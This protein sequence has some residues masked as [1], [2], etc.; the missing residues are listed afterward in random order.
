MS[1]KIEIIRRENGIFRHV[2]VTGELLLNA[3]IELLPDDTIRVNANNYSEVMQPNEIYVKDEINDSLSVNYET[4]S[5]LSA[6]LKRLG[7]TDWDIS[8]NSGEN[9]APGSLIDRELVATTYECKIAFAGASIGDTITCT[10][11]IDV[12]GTPTNISTIWRNQTTAANLV[13]VPSASN[14]SLLG[15]Q[16]LTNA[17]LRAAALIVSGNVNANTGLEQPL[18]NAELR[19]A[20]IAISATNLPLPLGASTEATL[21]AIKQKTDNID[22]ALSTRTKPADV[23]KTDGSAVVQPISATELPL[24]TGAAK[25]STLNDIKS[26]VQTIDDTVAQIGADAPAKVQAMGIVNP[27][28]KIVPA[29]STENGAMA[30]GNAMKKFR[31]G[32]AD[33]A[34]GALPD[35]S[36]WDIEW[37]SK[38]S[39]F[40]G[41][42]GDA[43]GASYMKISL[44]PITAGS[45]FSMITKRTFK[46]PMRFINMLSISQRI[47]GQEF[48]IS[49]VGVDSNG[50]IVTLTPKADLAISGIVGITSNIATINFASPHGLKTSDR[51][52]LVG[53]T[54]RRLNVGPVQ[55]TVVNATQITVPC[56]LANGTY[57]AGGVVRWADP[58]A[59]AK[60]GAGLLHENATA[61]NA[62][63]LTRR[64]GFN[65][66][67]LNSTIANTSNATNLGY[68]DPFQ[69]TSMNQIIA[70]Q[71]EFTIIPRSPDT[72]T[73]PSTPLKWHQGIPDE[74]IEY[75]IRI[76][77]KNLDNLTRPIARIITINKTG[78]TTATVVTDTPHGLTTT[79]FVQI[80]GVRDQNNFPTLAVQ[81]QVASVIDANTFTIIIGSA[82]SASS[83]GGTVVINQ[84]SVLFPGGSNVAVQSISR[85]NNVL[86]LIGNGTWTGFLPGETI[87][88]YGCDAT[89][90]G[91]YDGA[92]KVLRLATTTLEL[93]SVGVDFGSINCGGA[94]VRRTDL[95]INGIS[96]I[97]HTR[98][99]AELSNSQGSLDNSKAMPA[100]VVNTPS[101]VQSGTWNVGVTSL[102]ALPAGPNLIGSVSFPIPILVADIASAALTTTATTAA[103]TP[104]A[105][106]SYEINI[107]VTAVTGTNPTLDI[108]IE[109]SDDNGTNWYKV[110]DFPRITAT[111]MYR[112]PKL[113]LT[114]NRIRY[115]QT[116]GGTTPSFTRSLNRLQITDTIASIRQLIDR[117]VVLTTLNSVTPSINVQNCGNIQLAINVGTITTTAPQIQLQGSD[118]NG[119]TWYSIGTPLTAVASQT[120]SL[121]VNDN[122]AQ[123]VRAIVS[124][125]GVGVTAG[126]TLIK[127]Y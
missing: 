117:T 57:A 15:S 36:I 12:T 46:Y 4:A 41:R 123:L 88:L 31:D 1:K 19:A 83:T 21:L 116:V 3:Y 63:F 64:N 51:I 80:Y 121:K 126:Y 84:G 124:T 62:T 113:P 61:T 7:Y 87:H 110:Y 47:L 107:P 11:I 17:Q 120:V 115:V 48:E 104:G 79:D 16:A 40:A 103:F 73:A 30:I 85:T 22:V 106:V 66:R 108:S 53:N 91:L 114:G 112:S 45:Q 70:N 81:T 9:S 38:G 109:E 77:A 6:R 65:T 13:S 95:R 118:D 102:P 52:I 105:G 90:M 8:N 127:G 92:Y 27:S 29:P 24:P 20:A 42:A 49:L 54:E 97:E 39:S 89:S 59:Y 111:G 76:R 125:A 60:N 5:L 35:S 86:T 32:F 10:Q 33:L 43:Q 68:A 122:N 96:E 23:Q 34:Q 78:T 2:L 26:A 93:E 99:I 55:V 72:I 50:A 37:V 101:V 14:L 18:T 94:V 44:C 119:A 71:E 58:L 56:T 25:E 74:E 82:L 67:L 69:G 28:N 75:K 98:L 100:T